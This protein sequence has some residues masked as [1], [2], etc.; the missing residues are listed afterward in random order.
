[1]GVSL[2][3]KE[4]VSLLTTPAYYG[5]ASAVALLAAATLMSQMYMFAPGLG[6]P[7]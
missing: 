3:A 7:G 2:Y 6:I 1:M 5:A 4:L